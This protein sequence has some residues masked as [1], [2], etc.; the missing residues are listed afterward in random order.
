MIKPFPKIFAIGARYI[1]DIFEGEVEITEKID[2]SQ[3]V[4][5]KVNGVLH[6]RSKGA[7]V[8][9][10]APEKLFAEAVNYIVS[11]E[12]RLPDNTIFYCEYL[13]KPKHN[14]LAYD[15]TPKNHLILFGISSADDYFNDDLEK[16]ATALEIESVPVL[17]KGSIG[18]AEK[19]LELLAITSVLGGQ[20]IEGVVVKNYKK[21]VLVGGQVMPIM[22]GKYV[23]E[24]F[25]E[26]HQRDWGKEN[27]GKGKF[28][29]YA[30]QFNSAARWNKAVQHLKE[31]GKLESAP[32]DIGILMA[33]I[34]NDI[35]LEEKENIKEWLW[36]T[37]S[38]EIMAKA[39]NGFPEWYKKQLLEGSF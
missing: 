14:V 38:R 10:D 5:G 39:I 33:E 9:K 3:F 18:S 24:Q 35:M 6:M 15:R 1:P 12:G 2:G 28:E 29:V 27:T 21:T 32:Q 37:F 7:I 13:K 30:E 17:Y 34:K 25:K 36:Q 31:K 19:L 26:V 20:K 11:I 23:S 8:Y 22:A 4:F 16:W